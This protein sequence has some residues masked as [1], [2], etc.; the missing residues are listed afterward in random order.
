M[1]KTTEDRGENRTL[2]FHTLRIAIKNA[3]FNKVYKS[4]IGGNR[5]V[6]SDYNN[7][8]VSNGQNTQKLKLADP[9]NIAFG[10]VKLLLILLWYMVMITRQFNHGKL[11][12]STEIVTVTILCKRSIIDTVQKWC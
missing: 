4:K 10:L 7:S 9:W 8:R 6:V 2:G 3:T 11:F 1:N 5:K 12:P